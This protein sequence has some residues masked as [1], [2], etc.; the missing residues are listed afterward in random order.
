MLL[1]EIRGLKGSEEKLYIVNISLQFFCLEQDYVYSKSSD[2]RDKSSP[3]SGKHTFP[4]NV[5]ALMFLFSRP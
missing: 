2:P 3:C 4:S 1:E 5:V